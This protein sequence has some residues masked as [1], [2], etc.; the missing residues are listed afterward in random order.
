MGRERKEYNMEGL[1]FWGLGFRDYKLRNFIRR[2][3]IIF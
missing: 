3:T 1:G 2:L